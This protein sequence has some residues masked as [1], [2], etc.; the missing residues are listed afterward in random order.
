MRRQP[1]PAA[2]KASDRDR[3]RA[4]FERY[5]LSLPSFFSRKGISKD[6]S[7]ELAQETFLRAYQS[8]GSFRGEA[9]EASWLFTIAS[10]VWKNALRGR[11]AAKRSAA[12]V[13]L[14]ESRTE[15][16]L[17]A[18]ESEDA[19]ES[20]TLQTSRLKAAEQDPLDQALRSEQTR[21][22]Y[23][24]I[25]DLPPQMRR[26]VMLRIVQDLKY[27]EIAAVAQVSV[28]TVR[29]QLHAARERLRSQLK[30]GFPGLS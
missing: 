5:Y 10:N 17:E 21:L 15:A 4:L 16:S 27:S 7:L 28:Q 12:E 8:L 11:A 22:L 2:E 13:R 9:S 25:E 26:I 29:S 1:L 19:P 30:E 20:P 3:F 6:D 14:D 24:A 23:E 18:Q